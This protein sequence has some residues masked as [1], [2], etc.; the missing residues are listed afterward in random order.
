[1]VN[2]HS[3][4]QWR[5]Y[6]PIITNNDTICLYIRDYIKEPYTVSLSPQKMGPS[7]ALV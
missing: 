3:S 1:M 4:C 6:E 5:S 7:E 2:C